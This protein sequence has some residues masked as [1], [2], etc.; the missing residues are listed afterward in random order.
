MDPFFNPKTLEIE[1]GQGVKFLKKWEKNLEKNEL[2]KSLRIGSLHTNEKGATVTEPEL[3]NYRNPGVVLYHGFQGAW[4]RKVSD[5]IAEFGIRPDVT[6]LHGGTI[7]SEYIRTE[8]HEHLTGFPEIYETV[9]GRNGYLLFKTVDESGKRE[10]IE[11]VMFVIA[12][13]GDH[14]LFPPGYQHITVNLGNEGEGFLMTDW[15]S[16]NA[17]TD[18][19]Y[20]KRHNG[21]PYWVTPGKN[22]LDFIKN[23]KYKGRVPS[24]RRMKPVDEI[25]ELGLRK[26]RSMFDIENVNIDAISKFLNSDSDADFIWRS[27]VDY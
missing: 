19:K 15:V 20:I 13:P 18:F 22:G 23:P 21:A 27:L 1:L 25:P 24:V 6:A 4:K 3:W 11:N 2:W 12:E 16:P 14:V 7:G 10:D 26:G 17:K 8:G 9:H 5:L